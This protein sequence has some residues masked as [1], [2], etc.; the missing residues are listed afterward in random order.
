M[1]KKYTEL[2]HKHNL[3]DEA[4]SVTLQMLEIDAKMYKIAQKSLRESDTAEMQDDIRKMDRKV[5]RHLRDVRRK[6]LTHLTVTGTINLVPGLVLASI[7][8]DVERIG[9]YAKNIVD[10]ARRH[11]KRLLGGKYE[12]AMKK[13]EE[14]IA[15]NFDRVSVA[16][17]EQ[18]QSAGR[19][20]MSAEHEISKQC[21]AILEELLTAPSE[22][23]SRQDIVS[24][25]LYMRFLKRINAHL[26]NVA[27]AI[28]NPFPRISFRE[29]K[30]S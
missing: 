27:S 14:S 12:D 25:A 15:P 18:D 5:N 17:S 11:P 4:A 28:V 30:K 3:L 22:D 7:V 21:G 26:T 8:I 16:L 1:L 24:I 29:K 20:I 13:I 23:L 2:F 9:D 10:L 19:K 6:I